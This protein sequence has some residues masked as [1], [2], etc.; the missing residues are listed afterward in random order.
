MWFKKSILSLVIFSLAQFVL[1]ADNGCKEYKISLKKWQN[2]KIKNYLIKVDYRAFTPLSGLWEIEVKNGT[3]ISYKF[4][5]S[6]NNSYAE[7]AKNFTM[8]SLYKK[9]K[10]AGDCNVKSP[11]VIVAEYDNITG[12]IKKLSRVRN[13]AYT[14]RIQR[15]AGFAYE[16]IEFIPRN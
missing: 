16:V 8:D 10:G 13:P 1:F 12:Y 4:N 6:D 15:D 2:D 11:M 5:S 7:S 9:A 3:V 14:G